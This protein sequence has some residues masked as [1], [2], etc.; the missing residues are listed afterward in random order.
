LERQQEVGVMATFRT[1]ATFPGVTAL[2]AT[3]AALLCEIDGKQ[4]WIPQSQIDDDS[5]VWEPEQEGDLIVSQWIAE[6][7]GLV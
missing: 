7:K 6:Q 2:R 1:K 3:E 4:V 5:E